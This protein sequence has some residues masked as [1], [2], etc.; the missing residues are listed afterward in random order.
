VHRNGNQNDGA[1]V[2]NPLSPTAHW[3]FFH[4]ANQSF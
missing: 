2:I 3:L 4:F 1:I